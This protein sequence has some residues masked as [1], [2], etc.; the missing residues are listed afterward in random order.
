MVVLGLFYTAPKKALGILAFFLLTWVALFCYI[1][2]Y[3]KKLYDEKIL[4]SIEEIT[5]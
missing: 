4:D 1:I 3:D 5:I 2:K